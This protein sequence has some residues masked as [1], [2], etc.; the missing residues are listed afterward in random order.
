M[1][2]LATAPTT[3]DVFPSTDDLAAH[4]A[5]TASDVALRQGFKGRFTDLQAALWDE[6]VGLIGEWGLGHT[7][8][9]A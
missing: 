8:L 4:L 3:T 1:T 5:M 6:F 2:A 7:S 9:D